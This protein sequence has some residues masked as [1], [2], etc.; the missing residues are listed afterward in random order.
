[1]KS[2]TF[3]DRSLIALWQQIIFPETGKSSKSPH[4]CVSTG[5]VITASNST[6]DS[7]PFSKLC[8][9]IVGFE[10]GGGIEES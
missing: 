2:E 7:I 10:A 9:V 5:G 1:M 8:Q 6:S 4:A 3:I